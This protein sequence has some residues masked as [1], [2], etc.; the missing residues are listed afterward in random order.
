VTDGKCQQ[1][2]DKVPVALEDA[3]LSTWI[4]PTDGTSDIYYDKGSLAG[5]LLDILIRDASDNRM[6]LDDVM[7]RLY[8]STYKVGKGFT[9]AQWW[10]AV[11]AAAGGRSFA[12]FSAKYIDGREPF[13]WSTVGRLAGIGYFVDST[14]VVRLGVNTVGDSVPLTV[15]SVV[16]G[17][18]A[19][20]AGVEAGDELLKVGDIDVKDQSF[21]L[22]FRARYA[23]AEG[24]TI[25]LLVRRNG[26]ER[27]L[28]LIV[29]KELVTEAQLVWDPAAGAKA[30]RIRRGI[31]A[32]TTGY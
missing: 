27:T 13:P 25:S 11:S 10:A 14:R 15:I 4:E 17:G 12:D 8:R 16:T 5:L 18:A 1:V 24:T 6:S 21:G 23:N 31:L 19:A 32:G 28:P 22:A 20:E 26:A 29:R 30:A 7:R 3:S 9:T 2:D